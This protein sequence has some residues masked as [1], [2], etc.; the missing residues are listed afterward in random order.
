MYNYEQESFKFKYDNKA[1]HTNVLAI[2]INHTSSPLNIHE[3]SPFVFVL[4][5]Y[6]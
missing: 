3:H 5:S 4:P 1:L 6:N 2:H